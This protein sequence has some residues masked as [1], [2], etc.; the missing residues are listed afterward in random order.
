MCFLLSCETVAQVLRVH[1]QCMLKEPAVSIAFTVLLVSSHQLHTHIS[2]SPLTAVV[3]D[4][5][6]IVTVSFSAKSVESLE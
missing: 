6:V 2:H 5:I 1:V 4:N 3:V